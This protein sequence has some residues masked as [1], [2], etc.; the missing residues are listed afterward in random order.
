MGLKVLHVPLHKMILSCDLFQGDVKVGMCPA[1]SLDGVVMIFAGVGF[2]L[3]VHLL[4]LW[5]QSPW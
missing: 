1:M 3:M 5:H 4:P 2:G